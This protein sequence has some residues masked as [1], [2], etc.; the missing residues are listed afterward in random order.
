[1]GALEKDKCSSLLSA[2]VLRSAEEAA[3]SSL[4][5]AV[6]VLACVRLALFCAPLQL[7]LFVHLTLQIAVEKIAF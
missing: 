1:M 5:S 3:K 6:S 2:L 4:N 7:R